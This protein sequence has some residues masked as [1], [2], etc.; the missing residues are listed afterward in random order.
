MTAA[1]MRRTEK[2]VSVQKNS[3]ETVH[4]MVNVKPMN[5]KY[6]VSFI[7]FV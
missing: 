4:E 7:Q 5:A 2:I 1:C 6:R 3:I